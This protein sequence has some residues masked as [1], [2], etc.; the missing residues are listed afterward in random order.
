[1]ERLS[2]LLNSLVVVFEKCLGPA[3][4]YPK[5]PTKLPFHVFTQHASLAII[6]R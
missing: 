2:V 4:P 5:Q 1:M 6:V 3:V